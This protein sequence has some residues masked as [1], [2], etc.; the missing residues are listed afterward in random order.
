MIDMPLAFIAGTVFAVVVAVGATV[1]AVAATVA[2]V[3]APIV[4]GIASIVGGIVSAIGSVLGGII[5]TL[6][7]IA[8]GI[9][10]SFQVSM[11]QLKATILYPIGQI[12]LGVKAAITAFATAVTAPLAPILNPIKDSLITIKDFVQETQIWVDAELA[13]VGELIKA[14]QAISAIMVVKKLIDGTGDITQI[15]GGVAEG[16]SMKTAQAIAMLYNSIVDTT[17]SMAETVNAQSTLLAKSIDEYDENVRAD[18]K[19][20]MAMLSDNIYG[21]VD[22]VANSLTGELSPVESSVRMIARR[23]E[24]MPFFQ[25]MLIRSLA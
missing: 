8:R 2:A 15:L 23:T 5:N 22:M 7:Y 19:I 10:F 25:N 14:I 4:A 13:P 18:T 20:A 3:I 11:V 12:L 6:G 17:I 9:T 24:D 16:E 1:V 21:Q